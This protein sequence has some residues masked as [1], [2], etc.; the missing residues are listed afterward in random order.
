M[1]FFLNLLKYSQ[2]IVIIDRRSDI[3]SIKYNVKVSENIISNSF[4]FG[5]AEKPTAAKRLA[6]T[7]DPKSTKFSIEVTRVERGKKIRLP[8]T[9]GYS[10]EYSGHKV[11]ILSA[12]GHLYTLVQDGIG[13]QYPVYDF[14]WMPLHRTIKKLDES[15]FHLRIESAIESMKYLAKKSVSSII[16]TDYDEE[17]EVIGGVTLSKI[18]GEEILTSAKRMKFSTFAKKELM[19]SFKE[20]FQADHTGINDGMYNRGL[21]RHY[22]DWLWGINLSRALMLS[23]KN[24]SGR[25]HTLS[26]GRVQGP[27]LSFVIEREFDRGIFVPTPYFN[28]DVSIENSKG[29]FELVYSK[30]DIA[31]KNKAVALRKKI[32]DKIAIVSEVTK[33]RS[34]NNP[35]APY[36]LSSLQK[37]AYTYYRINPSRTLQIAEKL[38]LAAAISYPRTSSEK[39]PSDL[40]HADVLKKLSRQQAFKDIGKQILLGKLNPKEGK[41]NDPAHPCI[42][43]TGIKPANM[44]GA[45]MNVYSLIIYKYFATFGKAAIIES[46]RV[47]FDIEG[48]K[49]HINGSRTIDLGWKAW[50]G[51]LGQIR[52]KELPVFRK[53]SKADVVIAKVKNK[54]TKP[55]PALNQASL[56][57]LMEKQEIGTKATRS[58]IINSIFE[59]KY[60]TGD[61]IKITAVGEIVNEVLRTFSPQVISV[62]LSR[63]LD[64]MG[65]LIELS[66]NGG[67]TQFSL[68]DAVTQG[69]LN[70]HQMLVKLKE[71]EHEIGTMIDKQLLYL[72]KEAVIIGKCIEC[73]EGDLKIIRSISSGKRFVGCS[74]Y[75]ENKT[76]NATY[77]LPQKGKLEP[78]DKLCKSDNY[79]QIRVYGGKK[80]WNLCLNADCEIRIEFKKKMELSKNRKSARDDKRV[81]TGETTKTSRTVNTR[82]TSKSARDVKTVNTRKSTKT[83]K[84]A[85]TRKSTKTNKTAETRKS[86]K[87]NK[88]AKTSKSTKTNKTAKTRKSAMQSKE[89][90]LMDRIRVIKTKMEISKSRKSTK[91]G[92]KKASRT[93]K[94]RKTSKSARDDKTVK[95]SEST[96]TSKTAKDSKSAL[97][98]KEKEM[99]DRIRVIKTKRRLKK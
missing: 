44:R 13:W 90:E 1:S 27:T 26:T 99:M 18:L 16:M 35:P 94:T 83:N 3:L 38:Y 71:N 30:G 54:F 22:L 98:S 34:K 82:R 67:N 57:R 69:I 15:K 92:T 59:R 31:E 66:Y 6:Q 78:I 72:R 47:D 20:V 25:Y 12:F 55:P 14:K 56:L 96:K 80:P 10:M 4:H 62:E 64:K 93:V 97:Q 33:K 65:D 24:T 9:D 48:N 36:N 7:L 50:A 81:K 58:E 74:K 63:Q 19:N 45:D 32:K 41:K 68:Q 75:F 79:P 28:L 2:K 29:R 52:D 49:F 23:L 8:D 53:D 42:Y 21:M 43:P 76:C 77:P 61:P 11:L 5:L 46:N 85:E 40:S 91:T 73:K 89:Q 95:T 39:Y 70:L 17:G 86:T 51:V 87:T 60:L 84:T 37:D 88:T